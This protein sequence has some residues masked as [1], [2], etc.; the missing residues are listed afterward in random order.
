LPVGKYYLEIYS[1]PKNHFLDAKEYEF[2]VVKDKE[3]NFV[4]TV[5]STVGLGK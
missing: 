4:I 2:E 3:H 1:L 5:E